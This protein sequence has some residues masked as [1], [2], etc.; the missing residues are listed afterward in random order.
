M[1]KEDTLPDTLYIKEIENSTRKFR[2]N[3]VYREEM[4]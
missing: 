2:Q 4:V 1:H 3:I